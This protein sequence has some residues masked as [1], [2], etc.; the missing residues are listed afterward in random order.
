MKENGEGAQRDGGSV[1][2]KRE[3]AI[4]TLVDMAGADS[5]RQID[6][7]ELGRVANELRQDGRTEKADFVQGLAV[8]EARA[9]GTI[10]R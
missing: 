6:P 3:E 7:F 1:V 10:R 5:L 9:T 4:R 8:A 2:E